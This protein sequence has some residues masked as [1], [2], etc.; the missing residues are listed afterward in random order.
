MN[1]VKPNYNEC[2]TNLSNSIL[3]HFDFPTH[4]NTLEYIDKILEKDYKNVIVIL[5]DGLGSLLLDEMLDKDS[6][7][8]KNRLKTITS[9]YPPTTTAATTS[10]LSGLNP[11]E[12]GWL[13]WDLYFKKED[14]VVTMFLNTLKDSEIIAADYNIANTTYPYTSI[15]KTI[16]TKY[17]SYG[18]FSFKDEKYM[19]LKNQI[20][21][22]I[23]LTK[24]NNKKFI[25]AYY[26]NP[27]GFLH[28]YG[29]DSNIV[30][31]EFL[32]INNDLEYLCNNID[33]SVVIIVADH[34]HIDCKYYNL[35]N[36]PSIKSLLERTI[37]IEPRA[38][39][40]KVIENKYEEFILEFNK[41]FKDDF[42]L[43]NKKEVIESKIFGTGNNNEYFEEAIG[44]FVALAKS[45]KCIIYDENSPIFKSMHAG[46]TD[47][48]MLIPLIVKEKVKKKEHF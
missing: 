25:Y 13:G 14:K 29:I 24:T 8:I 33:D 11:N 47:R 26:P 7:L 17:E 12:H 46:L 10:M 23:K 3:K 37:S 15:I 43:L 48:E 39:S 2:I 27:D 40:F 19:V 41:Y 44:D 36:Y 5:C 31:E 1:I 4:H 20:E 30:K 32:N 9:V 28:D 38:V 45:D 6:F 34:G 42:I 18:I 35:N 21:D 16:S 22:I